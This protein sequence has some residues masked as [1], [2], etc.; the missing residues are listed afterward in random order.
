MDFPVNEP[1]FHDPTLKLW[2]PVTLLPLFSLDLGLN[3]RHDSL[4]PA[5]TKSTRKKL[6]LISP[7][8][9][10]ALAGCC[11]PDLL[12]S[13]VVAGCYSCPV[14]VGGPRRLLETE[15]KNEKE[16]KRKRGAEQSR[17]SCR[18]VGAALV[19][20]SFA[21]V[22]GEKAVGTAAIGLYLHAA[23]ETKLFVDT[24]RGETLRINFDITFP[25]I[26]CSI[27]SVDDMDIS[28][29]QHLD[30]VCAAKRHMAYIM[31]TNEEERVKGITV[32]VGRA[33][34]EIETTRFTI[35]DALVTFYPHSFSD[36]PC[37][38]EEKV[39]GDKATVDLNLAAHH[40]AVPL[41]IPFLCLSGPC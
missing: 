19:S 41:V 13:W 24:S 30:I 39:V 38:R 22:A 14:T 32:E 26:P 29:E 3:R 28:G 23:T 4:P 2:E 15:K 5:D 36:L 27:L 20:V 35:L 12:L 8:S 6:K 31:D 33:P 9:E 16:G 10:L 7:E 11:R 18:L 40:T 37:T 25:A 17:R 34:F 1:M 21:G